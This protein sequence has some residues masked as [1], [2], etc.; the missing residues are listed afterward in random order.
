MFN[1]YFSDRQKRAATIDSLRNTP[2]SDWKV[3]VVGGKWLGNGLLKIDDAI[4]LDRE[5]VDLTLTSKYDSLVTYQFHFKVNRM[6]SLLL[7][8]SKKKNELLPAG[9][10]KFDVIP[11]YADGS[12]G[13]KF[14]VPSSNSM[15]NLEISN[16]VYDGYNEVLIDPL[17]FG[18]AGND[19]VKIRLANKLG[20]ARGELDVVL[21]YESHQ[22][23]DFDG[24]DGADG[25]HGYDGDSTRGPYRG[26]SGYNGGDGHDLKIFI[27]TYVTPKDQELVLM[28]VIK[29]TKDTSYVLCDPKMS[30]ITISS[31]GGKGGDGGRGG[32]GRIKKTASIGSFSDYC[33]AD[34]GHG[35]DGGNGGN[36]EVLISSEANEENLPLKFIYEGGALGEKGYGGNG[37]GLFYE[38]G[39]SGTNGSNG[40]KGYLKIAIGDVNIKLP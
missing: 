30:F 17:P 20:T 19:T 1:R 7:K 27:D 37:T 32:D 36:I 16:G 5:Q 15:F 39:K 24:Y 14:Y 33:G 26:T 3:D 31:N 10:L 11:H 13:E 25:E 4:D 2:Y 23:L 40:K 18:L 12:I 9:F 29:E 38:S 8:L 28:Q 34:A 21:T 22:T 35:A 6:D